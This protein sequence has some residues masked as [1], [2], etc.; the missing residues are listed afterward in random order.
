MESPPPNDPYFSAFNISLFLYKKPDADV[1]FL[2]FCQTISLHLFLT[3][4]DTILT[5]FHQ[6]AVPQDIASFC[7]NQEIENQ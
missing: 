2:H 4:Y 7:Y 5:L 1:V 3:Y 6:S